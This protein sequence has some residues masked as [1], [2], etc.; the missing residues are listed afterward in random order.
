MFK[1]LCV[2]FIVIFLYSCSVFKCKKNNRSTADDSSIIVYRVFDSLEN[3]LCKDLNEGNWRNADSPI[4][5]I[6]DPLKTELASTYNSSRHIFRLAIAQWA[7]YREDRIAK[8]SNRKIFICGKLYPVY[9]LNVDD[10][11][12]TTEWGRTY[13]SD[14]YS[15]SGNWDYYRRRNYLVDMERKQIL[16]RYGE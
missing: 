13:K 15:H 16:Q 5:I 7:G 9:I 11:F 14:H 8:I 2:L 3:M 10:M 4:F 1:C 6:L 12:V